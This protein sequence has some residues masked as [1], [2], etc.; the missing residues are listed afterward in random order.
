MFNKEEFQ[1]EASINVDPTWQLLE[2][3]QFNE[4]DSTPIMAEGETLSTLGS[5]ELYKS[6]L[7]RVTSRAPLPVPAQP[8]HGY[9]A[10]ASA[11]PV[12][13]AYA[14]KKTARVYASEQV[15]SLLMAAPHT[16]HA[17]D[18]LVTK[19]PHG[20]FIDARPDSAANTLNALETVSEYLPAEPEH[21][22]SAVSLSREATAVA[23]QFVQMSVSAGEAPLAETEPSPA[24]QNVPAGEVPAS[25]VYRYRKFDLGDG[26][27]VLARTSLAAY[28]PD[29]EGKKQMVAVK[30]FN[31]ADPR[32]ITGSIDWRERLDSQPGAVLAA[33]M[34]NNTSRVVR[35]MAETFLSGADSVRLGW[36]TRL[37]AR[38]N[39]R[40]VLLGVS[41]YEPKLLSS[42]VR[43]L[44]SELWSTLRTVLDFINEQDDGKFILARDPMRPVI[45]LYAVNND[46]FD[47]NTG[48]L[49][50][51]EE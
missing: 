23:S 13:Q 28:A 51:M 27:T 42:A 33:E 14:G 15:L 34:K 8:V 45:R 37:S 25:L 43:V 50:E 48:K 41:T 7:N 11:D 35:A 6:G 29:S 9:N 17:W 32:A 26:M 1:R 19:T 46:V 39:T 44:R 38:D 21:I 30:A 47:A 20:I 4:L 36:L 18:V 16:V 10:N 40:H 2:E 3:I 5:L 22:N 31:E 24:A 12:M 49:K